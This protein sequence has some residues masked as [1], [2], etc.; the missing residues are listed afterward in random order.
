MK[1]KIKYFLM[2]TVMLLAVSVQAEAYDFV[3]DGICYNV[4]S[5]KDLT[6]TVVGGKEYEGDIVIPAQVEFNNRILKVVEI[7][8]GAFSECSRL[9]SVVLPNSVTLIGSKCFASSSLISV[10]I[11][12]SVIEIANQTF[13][14]CASLTSIE[15][16]NSVTKIGFQAFKGC[17]SLR[18]VKIPN[19]VKELGEEVFCYCTSLTSI[20]IPNSI[21]TIP[22]KA[23]R[24]CVSMISVNLP[25][26]VTQ[27]KRG[28]FRD[29]TA[30]TSLTL[31][32]NLT[33]L[34]DQTFADCRSLTSITIPNTLKKIRKFTF[35][36]CSALKNIIIGDGVEDIEYGVF[37]E[38]KSLQSL[39]IPAN[40]K[41]IEI[42]DRNHY[43]NNDEPWSDETF[44]GCESLKEIKFLNNVDSCPLRIGYGYG[45][46]CGDDNYCI[47]IMF[48]DQLNQQVEKMYIGRKFNYPIPASNLKELTI[49]ETVSE[50]D[51]YSTG[52]IMLIT[53][54][55]DKAPV[56]SGFT[57][58]EYM[59]TQVKVPYIA[60]DSYRADPVWG[61]FW[62][63]QGFD[64]SGVDDL[65]TEEP[66][67]SI[68]G[69]FDLNGN[70]VDERYKGI[71]A[72]RFSAAPT[73]QAIV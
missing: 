38:C 37:V 60:L 26:S 8:G 11:P 28:A 18:S 9:N 65:E 21:E 45:D 48:K 30:L 52:N 35:S 19:S 68:I 41:T 53:S 36:G 25:N 58:N 44:R 62:N 51:V 69:R 29:C 16:P 17:E 31:P 47:D 23:F 66:E 14:S 42:Y 64:P 1:S 15:I 6:C 56:A 46:Y 72:I 39:T 67:K 4:K 49:G 27:I 34:E 7:G 2:L 40:V 63:L 22:R 43:T 13:L 54:Y 12:N 33:K 50:L 71:A 70:P 3:V 55:A 10:T 73:K 59:N 61:N 20:T 24:L 5:F 57:H 32:N